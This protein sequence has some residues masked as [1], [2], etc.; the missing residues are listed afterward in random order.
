MTKIELQ[1]MHA[2]IRIADSLE[3]ISATLA[4]LLKQNEPNQP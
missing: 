4:K 2:I 1:T 3:E